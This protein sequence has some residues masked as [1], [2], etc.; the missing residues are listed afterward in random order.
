[1]ELRHLRYFVAVAQELNF[2]RAAKILNIAQPP[3]SMQI[4][5]L[6]EELG[7]KLFD[8]S[9][10]AIA[11]TPAG[12][13]FHLDARRVLAES[14]LAVTNVRK[15]AAGLVGRL[16]IGFML[17][18]ANEF[19]GEAVR[20]FMISYPSVEISL[21]DLTNSEQIKALEE[22]RIDIAF[23]RSKI[24]KSDLETHILVEEPMVM[25][26]PSDDLL[27]QKKRLAWKD[28]DGKVIVTIHPDLALGFYDNFFA[29]CLEAKISVVT[30]Q[31]ANDLHTEM[32]LVSIGMGWA[33]TS[34]TTSRIKRPNV[35]YCVLPANLPK[36]Q[37]AMS[38]KKASVSPSVANFI[39]VIQPLAMRRLVGKPG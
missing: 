5:S 36:V 20:Q 14:K 11:L 17:S 37:T 8:R 7:A 18:T 31:Y 22:D 33:P 2:R 1:M 9:N 23:T 38:W 39:E 13:Q 10:R 21:L 29:K 32:W 19:L 12:Q 26:V 30:G 25:M 3:L 34:L 15:A 4:R 6:E 27:S 28:L 24:T 16:N 35:S